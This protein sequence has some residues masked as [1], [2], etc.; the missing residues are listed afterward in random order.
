[1]NEVVPWS[2]RARDASVSVARGVGDAFH[3][4]WDWFSDLGAGVWILGLGVVV[5]GALLVA[6]IQGQSTPNGIRT[7]ATAVKCQ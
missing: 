3:S 6:V 1:M 2:S 4:L 7:R 5:G